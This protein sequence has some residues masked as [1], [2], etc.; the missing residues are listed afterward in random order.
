MIAAEPRE[1]AA[2]A[3]ADTSAGRDEA[4]DGATSAGAPFLAQVWAV[5][6][7]DLLLEARSRERL[8]SMATFAVL[9]AIVF[10]FAV[11]PAVRARSIGGA[12]IW[13]TVLFAGTLGMGR[14][15]ALEREAEALTGV[16]LA[17]V[18]RG[19]LFL[20]KWLAN[21]AVVLA[22]EALVFPVF[23]LFFNLGFQGSLAA[24][25]AVVVLATVGFIALGT[26]FGAIAAHTRLGE[27]LIPILLLPLLA[28]VVIF[29]SAATQRLLVGRP[30]SD[31]VSQLKMLG[32]FDL[33][34][35]FVC[36]ALFGAV[37]E[38]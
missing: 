13:V 35:L 34:F 28:P 32:A 4:W 29:A 12:M 25:V 5:A 8:M 27:T 37:M 2:V 3:A 19:A 18:D 14:G 30:V 36:T 9:V 23:G 33:V 38:E 7:K 10:S 17:P 22:V 11:D 31:V 15:W 20:G 24:L 6:R 21:M 16:L 26:L 1:P